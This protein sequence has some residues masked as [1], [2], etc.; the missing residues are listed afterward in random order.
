M[1]FNEMILVG[2]GEEWSFGL[3]AEILVA[4]SWDTKS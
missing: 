1:A 3:G 2:V 4:G